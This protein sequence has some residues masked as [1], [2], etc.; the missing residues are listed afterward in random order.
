[1]EFIDKGTHWSGYS[2]TGTCFGA[3]IRAYIDQYLTNWSNKFEKGLICHG[4]CIH[5]GVCVMCMSS[6]T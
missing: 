2:V 4:A 5:T 1:M 3:N 6:L